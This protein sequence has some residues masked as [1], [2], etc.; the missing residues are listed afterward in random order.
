MR[1]LLYDARRFILKFRYIAGVAPLQLYISGLTFAPTLSILKQLFFKEKPD[2]TSTPKS[3][4]DNWDAQLQTL[5]GHKENL[6]S[7]AFS[8]NGFL[9]AS[10]ADD[11][12]VKI[13]EIA[14]GTLRQTFTGYKDSVISVAFSS[15]T[16]TLAS[17]SKDGRIRFWDVATGVLQRSIQHKDNYILEAAFSLDISLLATRGLNKTAIW[18]LTLGIQKYEL[19]E[20]FLLFLCPTF[21]AN[22]LLLASASVRGVFVCDTITGAERQTMEDQSID[23]VKSLA[24]SPNGH[25]LAAS[26]NHYSCVRLWDVITGTQKYSFEAYSFGNEVVF[27]PDNQFLAIGHPRGTILWDVAKNRVH[28]ENSNPASIV[29]YSPDGRTLAS[30]YHNKTIELWDLD[31]KFPNPDFHSLPI[32]D[33]EFSS[34]GKLAISFSYNGINVWNPSQESLQLVLDNY[35]GDAALSLDDRLLAYRS[36]P[37][38]DWNP[39]KLPG[40]SVNIWDI[41]MGIHWSILMDDACESMAFSPNSQQLATV[42]SH[43]IFF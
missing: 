18:D 42:N 10:G 40:D 32:D 19:A 6:R 15:D 31:A 12:T 4:E 43:G 35:D 25:L 1:E 27:S 16:Q 2:W 39:E 33:I 37:L 5:E 34:D 7:I 20:S 22:G 8:S 24:F 26:Y 30:T 36:K 9:L 3:I 38:S 14:T 28:K 23:E 13:W 41:K 11:K 29:A 21:S 17:I